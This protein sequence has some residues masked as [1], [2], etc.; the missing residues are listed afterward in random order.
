MRAFVLLGLTLALSAC[1]HA[2]RLADYQFRDRTLGVVA[3]IP[4]RPYVDIG[5]DVDLTGMNAV[6]AILKVGT[7][8]YKESQAG[9]L[10]A[11]LDSASAGLD[12]ADRIAGTVLERSARYLG[13]RAVET[14]READFQLEVNVEEYGVDARDWDDGARFHIKARLLLLD[15]DGREVWEGEVDENEPVSRGWFGVG[16][17]AADIVTGSA[18]GELTVRELEAALNEV[19]DYAAERLAE[20]LREGAEKARSNRV[21]LPCLLLMGGCRMTSPTG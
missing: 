19:A 13:A 7:S 3:V 8:I 11:R 1:A 6:G 14:S 18:L 10:R 15:R 4:P 2:G 9:K 20:K 17:P 5:P 16:S 21:S 12:L